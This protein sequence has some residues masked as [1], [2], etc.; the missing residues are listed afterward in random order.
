MD[1]VA[2]SPPQQKRKWHAK[3]HI[4]A[5]SECDLRSQAMELSARLVNIGEDAAINA[6][7]AEMFYDFLSGGSLSF[8]VP[9]FGSA[10][11]LGSTAKD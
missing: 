11:H 10:S 6:A 2:K 5:K 8:A 4:S 1:V 3:K 9:P 7:R